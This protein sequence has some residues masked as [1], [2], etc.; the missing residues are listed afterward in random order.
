M[1]YN[2]FPTLA[3]YGMG[4]ASSH[5]PGSPAFGLLAAALLVMA[6]SPA[7]L[8]QVQK[9]GSLTLEERST[10]DTIPLQSLDQEAM[11]GAVIEGGLAPGA[12]TRSESDTLTE[13]FSP[14]FDPLLIPVD[15]NRT[16]ANRFPLEVDIRYQDPKN[17]PGIEFGRSYNIAPPL[18]NRTYDFFESRTTER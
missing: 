15:D 14:F 13:D 12:S 11:A 18:P 10:V 7:A 5:Q 6:L 17:I 9:S 2:R 3:A 1:T 4:M 16:G 8:A